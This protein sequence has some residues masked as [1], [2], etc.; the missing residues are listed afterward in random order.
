MHYILLLPNLPTICQRNN[1]K[2]VIRLRHFSFK[3]TNQFKIALNWVNIDSE[4]K[5]D[6][7]FK[8]SFIKSTTQCRDNCINAS[9][10]TLRL[11]QKWNY[12]FFPLG[13]LNITFTKQCIGL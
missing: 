1:E 11:F 8:P 13:S 10:F 2:V 3:N 4:V 9:I 5:V 12:R 6:A 7:M